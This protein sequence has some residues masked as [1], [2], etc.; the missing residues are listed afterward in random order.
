MLQDCCFALPVIYTSVTML[1]RVPCCVLR[2]ADVL[3]RQRMRGLDRAHAPAVAPW[4]RGRL[5]DGRME[6][7]LDPP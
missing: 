4:L 2:Q 6:P 7:L 1:A 5:A 3:V